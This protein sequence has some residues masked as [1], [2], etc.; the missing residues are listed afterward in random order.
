MGSNGAAHFDSDKVT[1]QPTL[2]LTPLSHSFA[3]Q[4]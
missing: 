4:I 1:L 2:L 3:L